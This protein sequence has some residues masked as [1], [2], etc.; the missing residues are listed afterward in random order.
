MKVPSRV[1][2]GSTE[3]VRQA[4]CSKPADKGIAATSIAISILP[5]R[6]AA[7]GIGNAGRKVTHRTRSSREDV[8]VQGVDAAL[9]VE[10]VGPVAAVER[11]VAV[12][13]A[14]EV[15]AVFLP[16]VDV[17]LHLLP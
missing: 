3:L 4:V 14:Q 13:A 7:G 6:Y 8:A 15:G 11:V 2:T 1:V 16:D 12:A 5:M 10:G 17:A 9:A